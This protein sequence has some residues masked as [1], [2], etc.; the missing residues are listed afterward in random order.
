M[1]IF[2]QLSKVSLSCSEKLHNS[3]SEKFF[4]QFNTNIHFIYPQVKWLHISHSKKG[5]DW[6][7]HFFWRYT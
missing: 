3:T 6:D 4:K 5:M 2:L 1:V 7:L